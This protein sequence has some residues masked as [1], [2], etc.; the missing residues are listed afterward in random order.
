MVS[1]KNCLLVI[2]LFLNKKVCWFT[3]G[4]DLTI[5]TSEHGEARHPC[6]L[7]FPQY[8]H[9][10]IVLGGPQGL[11]YCLENDPWKEDYQSPKGIFQWYLN[12]CQKQGSR[13]IRT[14]EALLI[15][16]SFFQPA[17]AALDA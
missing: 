14:E 8:E 2:I 17:L 11:E 5:G 1:V 12:T 4:Y 9:A 7:Q 10:L 15:S 16:L 13:T 6:K 3:D